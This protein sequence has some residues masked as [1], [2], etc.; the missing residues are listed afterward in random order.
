MSRRHSDTL[1]GELFSAIPAAVPAVPGAMDFRKPVAELVA[2]LLANAK[3]DRYDVAARISRLCDHET[4]KALLDSYTAP[5]RE[6]CNLPLWKVPAVE[7]ACN[8]RGITEWLVAV[9]GG[10]VLWGA[11]VLQA[12]LGEIESRIQQLQEQRRLVK[13]VLRRQGQ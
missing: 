13:D 2:G 7:V 3:R 10:R 4:S 5:S 12:D 9:H 8:S 6:E 11:Q 1:T